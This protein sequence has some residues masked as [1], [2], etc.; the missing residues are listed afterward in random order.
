[1]APQAPELEG[2]TAASVGNSAIAAWFEESADG[3]RFVTAAIVNADGV[4]LQPVTIDGNWDRENKSRLTTASEGDEAAIA[5]YG[6]FSLTR[7]IFIQRM[8]ADGVLGRA[9]PVSDFRDGRDA[10]DNS[11]FDS[12]TVVDQL[13]IDL[14]DDGYVVV[15]TQ[16]TSG[17]DE[18]VT[19]YR[20]FVC[21]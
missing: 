14:S 8:N 16:A 9:F 5:W 10:E 15:W 1:M 20:R 2:F 18:T 7:N 19:Y 6:Q 21:E 4:E 12:D 3:D 17:V 11:H 13:S